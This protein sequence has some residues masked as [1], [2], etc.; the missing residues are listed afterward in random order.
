[1]RYLTYCEYKNIGGSLDETAF[2]TT[3]DR[4]CGEVDNATQRRIREMSEVPIAVKACCRDLI[5]YLALNQSTQNQ[6]VASRS[7][8]A[9]SVSQSE[10]YAT[11]TEQDVAFGCELIIKAYLVGETD[12]YGTPLLYKGLC[13]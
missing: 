9:G 2:I 12:D 3:I 13:R 11:K 7:Q 1:M 4:A 5:G 8:S 10:S 6:V